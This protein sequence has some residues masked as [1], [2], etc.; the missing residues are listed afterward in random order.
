M[1]RQL[2]NNWMNSTS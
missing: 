2:V 1:S